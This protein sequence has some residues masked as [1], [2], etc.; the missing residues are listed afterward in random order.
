MNL[1]VF[2]P[3]LA[4]A[5]SYP[6]SKIPILPTLSCK[7]LKFD[8]FAD[9]QSAFIARGEFFIQG[10]YALAEAIK[11]ASRRKKGAVLLPSFHCRSMVEPALYLGTKICFY[12]MMA[13]LCPDFAA[14]SLV[15]KRDRINPSVLILPHYFGFPNAIETARRFCAENDIVLIEDCAHAFYGTHHS[16]PLGTFGSYAIASIWKLL[17]ARD[18]AV[19]LDNNNVHA[20]GRLQQP[21]L[22]EIKSLYVLFQ[23]W[24]ERKVN[25]YAALQRIDPA[26]VLA[27]ARQIALSAQSKKESLDDKAELKYFSSA[28]FK[29]SGLQTSYWLMKRSAH[30]NIALQRR[31]NYFKWLE[32]IKSIPEVTPLFPGLPEG[33]VPYAFPLLADS[34]GLIF[35]LLKLAGIPIW[36]WEDM[37]LTDCSVAEDY[38]LRLLQ[39]PCH[40]ELKQK[41]LDW[42][43]GILRS[44]ATELR[45]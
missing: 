27:Q 17:P 41:E 28:K 34:D 37:A 9:K 24:R 36:R 18:G 16:Q 8:R 32:A 19:L 6:K 12:R 22:N 25:S 10:R 23:K 20:T 7:S 1:P 11:R 31:E 15:L 5:S 42:M 33:V 21:W 35:H 40:Q 4:N 43:I 2:H 3:F 14:L 29:Y 38:R 44:V 26:F 39:L 30:T 45:R 13:D